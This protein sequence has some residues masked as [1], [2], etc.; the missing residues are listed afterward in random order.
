MVTAGWEWVPVA[1][2]EKLIFRDLTET[3]DYF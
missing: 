1:V 3:F 2:L